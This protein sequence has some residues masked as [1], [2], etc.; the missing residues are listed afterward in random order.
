MTSMRR[1]TSDFP[2][3]TASL[4]SSFPGRDRQ[5]GPAPSTSAGTIYWTGDAGRDAV[6]NYNWDEVGNWSTVDPLVASASGHPARAIWI[7]S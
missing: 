5:L 4:L 7:T 1:R 3:G 6:G 2:N